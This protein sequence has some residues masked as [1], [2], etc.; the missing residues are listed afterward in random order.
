[1]K[2]TSK[3]MAAS[4]AAT[5]LVALAAAASLSSFRQ[6][7]EGAQA[8]QRSHLAISSADDLLSSLRDAEIQPACLFTERRSSLS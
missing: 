8:R 7:E 6:I 1:M 3:I 2:A 4:A 5:L